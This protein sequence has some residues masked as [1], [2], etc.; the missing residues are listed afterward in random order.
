MYLLSHHHN[1]N[2]QEIQG[3]NFPTLKITPIRRWSGSP[4]SGCSVPQHLSRPAGGHPPSSPN[5]PA[6]VSKPKLF[7]TKN[8]WLSHGFHIRCICIYIYIYTCIYM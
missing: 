2:H 5:R 8:S 4:A 6:A 1:E 3:Y 7:T